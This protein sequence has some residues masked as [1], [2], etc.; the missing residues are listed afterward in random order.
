MCDY[1]KK[2]NWQG[3]RRKC[4]LKVIINGKDDLRM[5]SSEQQRL[6]LDSNPSSFTSL[7]YGLG[8]VINRSICKMET[9]IG[10]P[11]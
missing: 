10:P 9:I 1:E 5:L 3:S 4:D 7:L 11:S 2:E 8:Q 6:F